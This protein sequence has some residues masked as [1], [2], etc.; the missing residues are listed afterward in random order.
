MMCELPVVMSVG[1]EILKLL[2]IVK[3]LDKKEDVN[4]YC[5]FEDDEK[6]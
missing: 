2:G 4:V 6:I 3:I 5:E 1:K